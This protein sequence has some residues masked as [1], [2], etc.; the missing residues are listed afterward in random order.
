[1]TS[2]S[3]VT[4]ATTIDEQNELIAEILSEIKEDESTQKPEGDKR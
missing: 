3:R 4:S 1:M 2:G